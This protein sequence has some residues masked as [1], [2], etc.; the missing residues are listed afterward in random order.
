MSLIS[1]F[2]LRD[3]STA[4]KRTVFFVKTLF[5][6][7]NQFFVE[8]RSS[9]RPGPTFKKCPHGRKRSF[10]R[11]G[12][13]P[14]LQDTNHYKKEKKQKSFF[15]IKLFFISKM[16]FFLKKIIFF[17]WSHLIKMPLL[18]Q[19]LGQARKGVVNK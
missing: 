15:F 1:D 3:A 4:P 14:N 10:T 8:K 13:L 18:E 6:S 19:Q 17:V 7:K 16:Q 5:V 12:R 11:P 9:F 2:V